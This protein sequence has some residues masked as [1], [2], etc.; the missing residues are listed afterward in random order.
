MLNC[1]NSYLLA[2]EYPS[3]AACADVTGM[4]ATFIQG[5]VLNP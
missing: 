2:Y 3:R 4:R 1:E 5:A